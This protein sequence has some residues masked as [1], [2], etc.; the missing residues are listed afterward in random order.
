MIKPTSHLYNQQYSKT[1]EKDCAQ[2]NEDTELDKRITLIFRSEEPRF[3]SHGHKGNKT[4][5]W[6][7]TL[8]DLSW[9][10]V[11]PT[12]QD[13]SWS[14]T[15]EFKWTVILEPPSH[16]PHAYCDRRPPPISDDTQEV[17]L[18][19]GLNDRICNNLA[20]Q[21][22]QRLL[23]AA[24]FRFPFANIFI[25]LTNCSYNLQPNIQQNLKGSAVV[26]MDRKDYVQ[27][28]LRQLQEQDYYRP[29]DTN[30]S[31]NNHIHNL[32]DQLA[33]GKY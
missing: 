13:S 7:L 28:A 8:T 17:I 25:P 24:Q 21:M 19:F 26:I 20:L 29:L 30:T 1:Q 3:T 11:T 2:N 15:P 5:N 6:S 31:P 27:E 4:E 12:C 10:S 32:L 22:L 18:S 9:S 16:K 33:Q 23:N 14:L